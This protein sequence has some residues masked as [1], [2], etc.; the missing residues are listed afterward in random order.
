MAAY[1]LYFPPI[2]GDDKEWFVKIAFACDHTGFDEPPPYYKTE[3]VAHLAAHGY[4]V[5]DCGTSGPKS[6]DFP[7]FAAA[8][9]RKILDGEAERGVL[10]CGTGI[11]IGM[12]ANR[13]QG[14]R[15][16]VCTSPE[17]ARLARTHNDAN[18]IALGRRISTLEACLEMIDVWLD[19]E[20]SGCER[21]VRRIGKLG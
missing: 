3:I 6:V 17:M 10:L 7:D 2:W 1:S 11:G 8:A 20:F 4:E 5:V 18:V 19:T 21:H 15:A 12:A 16:A 14:I 9:C 13:F